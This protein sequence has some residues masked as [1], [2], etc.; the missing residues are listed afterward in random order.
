[1][2]VILGGTGCIGTAFRSAL[3][4]SG[5]KYVSV[6]QQR[7]QYYDSAALDDMLVQ[8][9]P[10]F[11]INAAGF[12]GRHNVDACELAKTECLLAKKESVA[13]GNA[14]QIGLLRLAVA[15]LLGE[16]QRGARVIG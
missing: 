9:R 11:L 6:S 10:R 12:A 15:V 2:I 13:Q 14:R 7:C 8:T 3:E 5:E 16:A 1:M 4:S